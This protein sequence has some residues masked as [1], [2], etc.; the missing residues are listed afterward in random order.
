MSLK[1]YRVL[2]TEIEIDGTEGRVAYYTSGGLFYQALEPNPM[3]AELVDN[4]RLAVV[5]KFGYN[6]SVRL[7]WL[8]FAAAVEESRDG[9]LIYLDE[10]GDIDAEK[11]FSH[12]KDFLNADLG[13]EDS[14]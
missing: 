6:D 10:D 3:L 5:Q 8:D 11:L 9:W 2:R 12:F 13:S 1:R 4:L 7:A 14:L